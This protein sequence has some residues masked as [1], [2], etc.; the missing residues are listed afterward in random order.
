MISGLL[1]VPA[2]AADAPEAANVSDYDTLIA[3]H[4]CDE[5]ALAELSGNNGGGNAMVPVTIEDGAPDGSKYIKTGSCGNNK[6]GEYCFESE[7]SYGDN[8]KEDV[9]FSLDVKF[10]AAGSGFCVED[11]G[12]SKVAGAVKNNGGKIAV[13][14][15]GS[16]Y[17]TTSV[18]I[19][20]VWYHIAM[21]GRY[22]ASDANVDMYIW[23]YGSDGSLEF[24]LKES[25]IALRN[26]SASSNNGA[27]HLNVLA[28]TCVDNMRVYKL[29]ADT[30]K[31]S[32]GADAVS[33]GETMLFTYS[34]E[35]AG[36]YITSP[37]VTWSVYNSDDTA[38]LDDADIS[39]SEGGLLTVGTEAVSQTINVRA[40]AAIKEDME[41]HASKEITINAIDTST[42][43]YDAVEV[44]A[45]ADT[46][47]FGSDVTFT[48]AA[49]LG[50]ES[51]TPGEGDLIWK[52]Y[53]AGN[54][55]EIGNK[56]ITITQEGVLSVTEDALPQTVTVR[57]V[58]K[59]GSVS[60][61]CQVEVLPAN[62]NYGNE[63]EYSDTFAAANACEEYGISSLSLM[64]GSWDGSAYYSVTAAYDFTGF[65]SNTNADV[66]YSADMRFANDGAGW[67]IFSNDKGKLGLQLS[68]SG[69]TLNALG[70]SNKTVGTMTGLDNTA[71]YNVQ[72]MCATGK[73]GSSYA[74]CSVYKYD[75]N[76]MR[77][78]P[79]TGA[80]GTPYNLTVNLRNLSESTANHININ[81]GTEVD[82]VL[83]MY[84]S[85]DKLTLS[86]D[87]E[88]VLAGGTA[89]A[90]VK[91]SRKGIEFPVLSA[92]LIKYEIYDSENKYPLGSNLITID[93]NGKLTVDAMADAQD[94]YVRVLSASGGMYDS[95]LL[96]I[97]SSDIFEITAAGFNEDYS[98]LQRIEVTKNF[99]YSDDVTFISA[100]YGADGA[101]KTIGFRKAYGDQLSLGSN[102]VSIN[103]AMPSD[104]SKTEDTLNAFTI[105]R[106]PVSK[107]AAPDETL[108]ASKTADGIRLD[109]VPEFT[110]RVI[111][112]VLKTDDPTKVETSDIAYFNQIEAENIPEEIK[113]DTNGTYL[114]EIAG[115]INGVHTIKAASVN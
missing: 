52:V 51:V 28:D 16:D 62:M 98:V 115:K 44:T 50:G 48:A 75:E 53:N 38:P 4:T 80:E 77:V 54:L 93:V 9:M 84:V 45:S 101:M 26:L 18:T 39:I 104:F 60:G 59:S 3:E 19:E 49:T 96:K 6:F 73:S 95:K 13:Q 2:F 33:V 76:G 25:S 21:I 108:T 88:T 56:N 111:I 112:L 102:R 57:A 94:I 17:T 85:P 61:T 82:N 109:T 35:R 47:R 69:T 66:I 58:N 24:L 15:S 79:Q 106:L 8:T 40:T 12:D 110:G 105:T 43:T 86:V 11:K 37:A 74:V 103:M 89:Q 10:G 65:P 55:R 29:G 68:S 83:C 42:D 97:K 99:D 64:E 31:L 72:I 20:D 30:L 113:L 107:A 46:V 14:R 22:S 78:N 71:W 63:D 114:V 34:A 91:A 67:T 27:S 100:V 7:F 92:G 32:S 41:I 5:S 90:S 81:A 1:T 70:A 23:K 36:E 87:A